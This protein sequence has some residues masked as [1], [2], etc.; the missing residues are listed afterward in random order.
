M[1]KANPK[2]SNL[3]ALYMK[4]ADLDKQILKA[5][6]ELVDSAEKAAGGLVNGKA[7]KKPVEAKPAATKPATGKRRGRKPKDAA[8]T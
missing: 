2:L 3:K 7:V 6:K 1:R 4:R 8:T 5:E